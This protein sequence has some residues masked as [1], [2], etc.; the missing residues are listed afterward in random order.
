MR[1]LPFDQ[2]NLEAAEQ[3]VR[4][5]GPIMLTGILPKLPDSDEHGPEQALM[6]CT[7]HQF[8]Q[9]AL[10]NNFAVTSRFYD[11]YHTHDSNP[12]DEIAMRREVFLSYLTSEYDLAKLYYK[13]AAAM[14]GQ[15]STGT[16][17]G[18]TDKLTARQLQ[19]Y[20]EN[21]TL[22]LVGKEALAAAHQTVAHL[23]QN[24]D[25]LRTIVD[26]LTR[27]WWVKLRDMW[28]DTIESFSSR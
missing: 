24:E 19:L 1:S 4:V 14:Q 17:L 20:K 3:L 13:F 18:F 8:A 2:F 25:L 16:V 9:L 22:D 7:P 10:L 15:V 28:R 5:G 26:T 21:E 6:V 12:E 27:P 23:I 11:P